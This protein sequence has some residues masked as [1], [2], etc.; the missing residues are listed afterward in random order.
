LSNI[1]L[2][3]KQ[4]EF[5]ALIGGNGSGK[6]TFLKMINSI[7]KPDTGNITVFG[8]NTRDEN[9]ILEIRKKIGFVFQNPENQIIASTVEEDMAFGME[10]L[11]FSRE[12]MKKR[13][14]ETLTFVGLQGCEKRNPLNLS[15]GQKQ[16]L[17][18]ASALVLDPE[19]LLLDEPM[20]MLDPE[21]QRDIFQLVQKYH[22]N[23]KTIIMITHDME[24]AA[25]SDRVCFIKKGRIEK[26]GI[27][28]TVI[29]KLKRYE[30]IECSDWV[31]EH[32]KNQGRD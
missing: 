6:S 26:C 22:E 21:G 11:G 1:S 15:G 12:V 7:L 4:G 28:K 10:N 3:I 29:P 14:K 32:L 5:L 13:M 24:A 18:I 25:Y 30:E 9:M 31:V 19:I 27:P 20:S 17:A 16:R 8:M 2:N 23:K